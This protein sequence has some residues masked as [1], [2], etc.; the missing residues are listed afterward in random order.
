[1]EDT[2]R[3]GIVIEERREEKDGDR[4]DRGGLI[5]C[6]VVL[7]RIDRVAD[8]GLL[9]AATSGMESGGGVVERVGRYR[10]SVVKTMPCDNT[11][12]S[13]HTVTPARIEDG[14]NWKIK[15]GSVSRLVPSQ[16]TVVSVAAPHSKEMPRLMKIS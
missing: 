4:G 14:R 10:K 8:F 11:E 13:Q 15:F 6:A 3:D 9:R 5:V 12:I 16:M 1:M 7:K 2:E